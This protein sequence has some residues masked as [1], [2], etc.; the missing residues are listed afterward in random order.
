MA[1]QDTEK[2]DATIVAPEVT[3]TKEAYS[4][5]YAIFCGKVY[6]FCA[7]LWRGQREHTPETLFRSRK[8]GTWIVTAFIVFAVIGAFTD[9]EEEGAADVSA[10]SESVRDNNSSTPNNGINVSAKQK[11]RRSIGKPK[12]FNKAYRNNNSVIEGRLQFNVDSGVAQWYNGWPT[13]RILSI[14]DDGVLVEGGGEVAF[15]KTSTSGY[16]DGNCLREGLYVRKGTYKYTSIDGAMRTIPAFEEITNAREIEIFNAMLEDERQRQLEEE[17][18]NAKPVEGYTIP[19]PQYAVVKSICGLEFGKPPAEIEKCLGK[20]VE[21]KPISETNKS[22]TFMLKKPFRLCDRVKVDYY[23]EPPF[24]VLIGVEFIGHVDKNKVSALSCKEEVESV[25]RML[26]EHFSFKYEGEVGE[27]SSE[28]GRPYYYKY[29]HV[30]SGKG[31]PRS[32]ASEGKIIVKYGID[33]GRFTIE[34][35]SEPLRDCYF[36]AMEAISNAVSDEQ[37]SNKESIGFSADN[38]ADML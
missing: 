25:S 31:S 36:D 33:D 6:D 34:Y 20:R 37:E 4:S 16:V 19:L 9:D 2:G 11:S 23:G 3:P 14:D 22:A 28:D 13:L 18:R 17:E 27:S 38:G 1:D 10:A 15:M 29:N 8:R 5:K 7:T 12:T 35:L 24:M 32:Y 30:P 21:G 26:C